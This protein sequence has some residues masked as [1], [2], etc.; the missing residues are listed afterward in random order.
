MKALRTLSLVLLTAF[1]VGACSSDEITEPTRRATTDDTGGGGGGGGGATDS[2]VL[3]VELTASGNSADVGDSITLTAT[4]WLDE[5]KT[6]PVTDGTSV[7]FTLNNNSVG[8]F[9]AADVDT[10]GGKAETRLDGTGPGDVSVQA[11]V[12]GVL[13]SSVTVTFNPLPGQEIALS[14]IDILPVGS[15]SVEVANPTNSDETTILIRARNNNNT[16]AQNVTI[17]VST[18]TG[19]LS[20]SRVVTDNNGLATVTF[21]GGIEARDATITATAEDVSAELIITVGPGTPF[22]IQISEPVP[23]VINLKGAGN[24][25]AIVTVTIKDMYGNAVADN[26]V[27]QFQDVPHLA[28]VSIS[29]VQGATIGGIATVAVNAGGKSGST[30]I[31]AS[32]PSASRT[33][34]S[35]KLT[36]QG[37]L[38]TTENIDFGPTPGTKVMS[39]LLLSGLDGEFVVRLADHS[40][41]PVPEGTRVYLSCEVGICGEFNDVGY[42]TDSQGA[43]SIPFVTAFGDQL[44]NNPGSVVDFGGLVGTNHGYPALGDPGNGAVTIIAVATG[45]S[46]FTDANGDGLFNAVDGDV[47]TYDPAEPFVDANENDVYDAGEDFWDFSFGTLYTGAHDTAGAH[48]LHGGYPWNGPSGGEYHDSTLVWSSATIYF[49]G[50]AVIFLVPERYE[51]LTA[52]TRFDGGPGGDK[53]VVGAP[54]PAVASYGTASTTETVVNVWISDINANPLPQ[55]TSVSVNVDGPGATGIDVS[56]PY[57]WGAYPWGVYTIVVSDKDATTNPTGSSFQLCVDVGLSD[58]DGGGYYNCINGLAY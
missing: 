52:N 46:S 43:V 16:Y 10:V 32:V 54:S 5:A 55:G 57:A 24:E 58:V 27:V 36:L 1:A 33:V 19:S 2:G 44:P 41:N 31:Q 15:T 18:D 22:D 30:W 17:N 26:T 28:G 49:T 11:E 53:M 47:V 23:N 29:P 9:T 45:Q 35:G 51:E 48:D 3:I 20:A 6:K 34:S 25:T 56:E 12:D 50:D 37:G 4:G 13:S 21:T 40:N 42:G 7:N 14:S 39:G 8:V 38:P